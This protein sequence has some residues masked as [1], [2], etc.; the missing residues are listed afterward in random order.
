[1]FYGT[2][3]RIL[4]EV[5]VVG[6]N[7]PSAGSASNVP[8]VEEAYPAAQRALKELLAGFRGLPD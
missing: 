7:R 1:M 5:A 3:G 8:A 4:V 6:Q 2:N